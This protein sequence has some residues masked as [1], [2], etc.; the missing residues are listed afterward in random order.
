[1]AKLKKIRDED[2]DIIDQGEENFHRIVLNP[3]SPYVGVI[4]Q[5]GEVKLLEENDQLRVR[6]QFEVFENPQK[7]NTETEEFKA[8]IGSILMTNLEEL[9]VFNQYQKEQGK[10]GD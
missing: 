8:Y 5:F 9:L 1:M 7:F 3:G 2:Y 10:R 6:F 4:F